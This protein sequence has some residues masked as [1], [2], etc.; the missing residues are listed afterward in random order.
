MKSHSYVVLML[1]LFVSCAKEKPFVFVEKAFT[2]KDFEACKVKNCPA[3]N[4]HYLEAAQQDEKAISVNSQISKTIIDLILSFQ[5]EVSE[6]LTVNKAVEEFIE[7]FQQYENDLGSNFISYDADTYMQVVYQSEELI[8]MDLNFYFFTGG[9][10]GYGGTLFLNFDAKT[11]TLLTAANLFSEAES[12]TKIA[13]E[14][15]REQYQIP[16]GQNINATGFWFKDGRFHLPEN[17]GV[18]ETEIILLYNAYEI[19]SY[20][21]GTI[22]VTIPKEEIIEILNYK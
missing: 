12:I 22:S 5:V 20:A 11:G 19:A 18:T 16:E 3:I 2:E 10:H 14:K 6:V 17:I 4:I 1:T 8:S 7:D 9:A 21:E 13:E 15:I